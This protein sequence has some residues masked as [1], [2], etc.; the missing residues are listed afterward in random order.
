MSS[1][2]NGT[3]LPFMGQQG[4]DSIVAVDARTLE[5]GCMARVLASEFVE[6]EIFEADSVAALSSTLHGR[7]KLVILRIYP[8]QQCDE[9]I[10]RDLDTIRSSC[11]NPFIALVC[12]DDESSLTYAA[13]HGCNGYL[14][15]SMPLPIAVAA[16]RL[17]LVGGLYF[18]RPIR[19][20]EQAGAAPAAAGPIFAEPSIG[21]YGANGKA[22][23]LK[24]EAEVPSPL[25]FTPRELQV[26]GALRC[27]RSNKV[28]ASDLKLSE[29]TVKVHVRH[30]M[31]KLRATNRTQAALRSELLFS[32]GQ[33]IN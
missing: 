31:R 29:N 10:A 5:R 12:E 3:T 17:V 32:T 11:S 21:T 4:R 7:P 33:S 2:N 9:S 15:T 26:I 19:A 16:L 25:G 18:P 1:D 13:R 24:V 14:P 28:I 8:E 6:Y 20:A 22:E 30:I 23:T 27:G